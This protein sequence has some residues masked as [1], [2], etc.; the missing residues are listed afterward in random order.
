VRW[1]TGVHE[2]E[3]QAYLVREPYEELLWWLLMPRLLRLANA[4][5]PDRAAIEALGGTVEKALE[6]AEAAGYRIEALLTPAAAAE[7]VSETVAE[8][9]AI[10]EVAE[11]LT[12][13]APEAAMEEDEGLPGAVEMA[14]TEAATASPESEPETPANPPKPVT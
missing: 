13:S 9:E 3:G 14:P 1:L 12:E 8:P 4:P 11:A 2:A 5:A 7:A 10:A 6:Q